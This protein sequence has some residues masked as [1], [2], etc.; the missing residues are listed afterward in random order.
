MPFENIYVCF[1]SDVIYKFRKIYNITD[2]ENLHGMYV[3]KI[4]LGLTKIPTN[5]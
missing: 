4:Q 2:H 3:P 1:S 5:T